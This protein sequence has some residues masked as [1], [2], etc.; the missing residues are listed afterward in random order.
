[1]FLVDS[2]AFGSTLECSVGCQFRAMFHTSKSYML[3]NLENVLLSSLKQHLKVSAVKQA[4]KHISKQTVEHNQATF[5]LYTPRHFSSNRKSLSVPSLM[6]DT[7]GIRAA[8]R[9][10]LR[11]SQFL[12]GSMQEPQ[13]S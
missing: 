2:A 8:G 4:N 9:I 13:R 5:K 3:V 7:A 12:F 11:K 1:M 10:H 6:Q